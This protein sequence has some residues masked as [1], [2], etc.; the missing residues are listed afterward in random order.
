MA[1]FWWI[2][3]YNFVQQL[4]FRVNITVEWVFFTWGGN[5]TSVT[6]LNIIKC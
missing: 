4:I 6:P 2:T 5:H 3:I 1:L